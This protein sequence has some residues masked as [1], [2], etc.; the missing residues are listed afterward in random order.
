MWVKIQAEALSV[1][2]FEATGFVGLG[3]F[4]INSAIWTA[5]QIRDT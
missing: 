3:E 2:P 5:I 4:S 1:I